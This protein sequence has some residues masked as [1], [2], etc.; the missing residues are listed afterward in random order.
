MKASNVNMGN[1]VEILVLKD[2]NILEDTVEPAPG[3]VCTSPV[4]TYLDLLIA[5][6]RGAE[7]ADYLRRKMLTWH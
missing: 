5:G 7:S 3:V 1:N 2:Q 6:D 4:Q